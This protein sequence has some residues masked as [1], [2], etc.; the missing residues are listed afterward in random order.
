MN[1]KWKKEIF[2]QHDCIEDE[3]SKLYRC[4]GAIKMKT[5]GRGFQTSCNVQNKSESPVRFGIYLV[6]VYQDQ[7]AL[8]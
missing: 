4:L 3:V 6:V 5:T 2:F 8:Y 1:A 7:H